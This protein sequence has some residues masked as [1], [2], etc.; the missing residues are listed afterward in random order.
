M[1]MEPDARCS[2]SKGANDTENEREEAIG[3]TSEGATPRH[4]EDIAAKRLYLLLN[5]I[6]LEG[7]TQQRSFG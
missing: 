2:R 6:E 3:S 4:K 7:A 5:V 1:E